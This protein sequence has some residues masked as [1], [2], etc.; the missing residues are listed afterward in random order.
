MTKDPDDRYDSCGAFL[1]ML[2]A[3]FREP[4]TMKAPVMKPLKGKPT[5]I[6][7]V[8]GAMP[9]K[10]KPASSASLR[11]MMLLLGFL[12]GGTAACFVYDVGGLRSHYFAPPVLEPTPELI[13]EPPAE[14]KE[15]LCEPCG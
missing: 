4:T 1:K 9:P 2:E 7:P 13:L 11:A 14:A 6:K 5:A 10:R 12:L 8:P 15:E 3:G